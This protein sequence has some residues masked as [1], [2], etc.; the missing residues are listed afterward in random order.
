M[1]LERPSFV[2]NLMAEINRLSK[3]FVKQVKNT[4]KFKKF[5]KKKNFLSSLFSHFFL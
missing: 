5:K 4:K 1:V 2:W 3:K